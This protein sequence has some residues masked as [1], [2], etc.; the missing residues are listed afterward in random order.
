MGRNHSPCVPC[1][2]KN[3]RHNVY[4][5]GKAYY[6]S[7]MLGLFSIGEKIA[8]QRKLLGLNQSE[9][10]EQARISR[11]T[12]Q[13]LENGRIGELGFSKV[14]RLLTALGLELKIQEAGTRRPTLDEL[15]EEARDDKGL[16]RR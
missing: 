8:A 11:A 6:I 15:L 5:Y 2:A 13:A 7:Q 10:A 16:D 1:Y 4:L 12:L 9:L 14:T 3:I